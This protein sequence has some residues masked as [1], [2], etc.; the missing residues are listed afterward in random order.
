MSSQWP[1]PLGA[2]Q[3]T[4]GPHS[5]ERIAYLHRNE[6]GNFHYGEGHPMKPARL[7]LTHNLVVGYGLHRKM[8]VYTPRLATDVEMTQ[9]HTED[10]IAFLQSVTPDNIQNYTKFLAKHSLGVDDCP[11]FEGMFDFCRISAGGSIEGARKL[12][13][14]AADIAINWSGGL[15]HAKKF[16]ASGFCYVNDIV[17]AIL[18][19][20]R[21]HPRVIY[22]DIDVHHGDGVQEAFYHSNRVM[23]VSFHRYDGTFFPGT[24]SL[25]EIGAREGKQYSV[26]VPLLPFI[27]DASYF[28]IFRDVI[29]KVMETFRPSV[30]VLQCGADSLA[31]DRL[32]CFN[33]SIKGHGECVRHMKSFGLPMLVLGGGGYTIR[34][35]ARCWTYETS[36]LT[37]TELPNDLPYNAYLSHYGPDF[38]LHPPIV[39][40]HSE[41]LNTRQ[42]LESVR[43]SIFEQLRYLDG[44]P[45]VQ[46]QAIPP[47]LGSFLARQ[48]D[49]ADEDE[50]RAPDRRANGYT[51][52]RRDRHRT[53]V[54]PGE[55]YDS[56][57]DNDH[58]PGSD[59]SDSFSD[60]GGSSSAG[61]AAAREIDVD[62][63]GLDPDDEGDE[64]DI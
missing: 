38:K 42:Y 17:L 64:L 39:D 15:H 43:V 63:A 16:E 32:G 24:G 62:G 46:M 53:A 47:S 12:N 9:F 2:V 25:D 18:E 55:H 11:V 57:R 20:L 51:Y 45:S 30:I 23:T 40:G 50:D 8:N 28:S 37:D 13:A 7:A 48:D 21:Y 61:D 58:D 41:N 29:N 4:V 22:I 59:L 31:S 19:L 44:A 10:Y 56:D 35:V 34:N 33:L 6:V 52:A 49:R 26:N 60:L 36:V 14:M 54:H 1:P 27:D 3:S 5:K